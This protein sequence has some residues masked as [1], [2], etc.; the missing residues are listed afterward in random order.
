METL[1]Y[2]N[3][4]IVA[5]AILMILAA[6]LSALISIGR[7]EDPTISNICPSSYKLEHMAA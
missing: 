4:R 1:F 6:G 3:K 2:R 7:Q 5:L